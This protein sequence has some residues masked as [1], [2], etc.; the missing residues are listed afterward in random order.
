[1]R[2]A[3]RL[4]LGAPP[5]PDPLRPCCACGAAADPAGPYFLSAC[6]AQVAQRTAVHHHI[7]AL[8]AAAL[9]RAPA[10]REVGVEVFPEGTGG[11][12]RPDLRATAATTASVT[13]CD[14]SVA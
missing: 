8:V 5:R 14:V 10:W 9:R 3:A 13:W 12:L 2:V 11:D 4:W 7:V 6:R 1:M